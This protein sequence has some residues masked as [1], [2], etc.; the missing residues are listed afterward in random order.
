MRTMCAFSNGPTS[1]RNS[2]LHFYTEIVANVKFYSEKKRKKKKKT[3]TKNELR[4]AT[5]P[6]VAGKEIAN[7]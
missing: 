6:K 7:T 4:V 2:I 5:T 1:K 3:H